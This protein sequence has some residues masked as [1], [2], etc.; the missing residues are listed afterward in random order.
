[1]QRTDGSKKPATVALH[2]NVC[3]SNW[4]GD[5]MPRTDEPIEH[6][7][8]TADAEFWV[9]LAG[10]GELNVEMLVIVS[11]DMLCVTIKAC[12]DGLDIGSVSRLAEEV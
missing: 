2:P 4:T 5:R 1:M 8:A 7:P 3:V 9:T 10:R 6:Q 11:E 12:N